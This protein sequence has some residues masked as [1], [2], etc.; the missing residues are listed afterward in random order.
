MKAIRLEKPEN[1][2]LLSAAQEPGLTGP[3]DAL[4]RVHRIGVCGTDIH[5][6]NG[7]QPFFSYPR[8][9]G[10]ELGVEVIKVGSCVG[11]V[12]PGDR[13]SVEP[14][15]NCGN[16]IA[17][18]RNKPNCCVY[19]QVLGVH[20]D[21]GM[22]ESLVLPA[23]KLHPSTTLT[24]DQ[25]ALVETL[26]IGCHA[27]E[28][29]R[30][31]KDEFVLVIGAGPIG[32]AVT[33]FSIEA[34]ARVIIIDIQPKRLDFC[35]DKLGVGYL[36]NA[37]AE[38]PLATLKGITSGDL[39]TAVFDATGNP[40][41]MAGAFEYPAHGGRLIFVGLFP[42][43]ITFNDPNFHRRELSILSSRNAHPENFTRIIDLVETGRI[44]TAPWISHRAS[45][46]DAVSEFPRWTR[47]ETGV[48]KAM[49]EL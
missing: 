36:V 4:V 19:L 16:C 8:I 48:I 49:I 46:D 42:G 9:L 22:R 17:C 39:P 10:H 13:C 1:L 26:G 21:G 41:S 24:L 32:L 25:L 7:A 27:V 15:L 5:A 20:V 44:D 38:D 34:G 6:F 47:P 11:N 35:R 12:K 2:V 45:F 33:Q 40:K 28:R 18:R 23:H 14:Y 37:A 29:A 3:D 30:V 43:D 31:E